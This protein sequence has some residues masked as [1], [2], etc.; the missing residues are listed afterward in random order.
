MCGDAAWGCD[1]NLYACYNST[2]SA[3]SCDIPGMKTS[4]S[5]WR[6]YGFPIDYCLARKVEPRCKLQLSRDI[7]VAVIICNLLK[8]AAMIA[9]LLFQQEPALVTTGDAISSWLQYPDEMTANQCL[10]NAR[11]NGHN[12]SP[13]SLPARDAGSDRVWSPVVFQ[14]PKVLRWYRAISRRRWAT[15]LTLC[16]TALAIAVFLL[17]RAHRNLWANNVDTLTAGGFGAIATQTML[18]TDLP[19]T[20]TRGLLANVLIANL[21]QLVF[22]CL[23]LLYNG[24]FTSM[25]LAHEYSNYSIF[26]KPL[27]VTSPQGNQRSTH[28]LHLPYVYSVPLLIAS[29]VL[30]WSISESIFF[31]GVDVYKGAVL[32]ESFF[33]LGYSVRPIILDISLGSL[34]LLVLVGMGFRKLKG[35]IPLANSNSFAIAAACHRPKDDKDAVVKGVMWGEVHTG[36]D[37]EVGHCSFTSM[38]VTAPVEGKLYAGFRRRA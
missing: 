31:V 30:H 33:G 26:R 37:S 29:T 28:W 27:R 15:V 36:A 22:S 11:T 6:P 18:S 17:W 16:T 38:E 13:N 14:G 7:L 34:M 21:P 20:G 25:C 24:L 32:G 1:D 35:N 8:A 3:G 9:T 10:R 12:T 2:G 4:P 5:Q 23:Y 19:R